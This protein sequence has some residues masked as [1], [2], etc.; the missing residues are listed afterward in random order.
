MPVSELELDGAKTGEVFQLD[1][2]D[3]AVR[4][5]ASGKIAIVVDDAEREN[6]GD[7]V[8]AAEKCSAEAMNFLVMHARGLVCAPLEREAA[9]RLE[10]DLMVEKNTDPNGTA[11]TVSVDAFEGVTTGISAAERATTARRLADPFAKPGDFRRP[12]HIFPLIARTGG[13][14]KRAGHTEAAVDLVRL[15]GFSGA[16]VICEILNEDGTMARLPDLLLLARRHGLR[17]VSVADLISYRLSREK[18]VKKMAEVKFP[19]K[20]GDFR[21]LAYKYA[22]DDNDE[23]VHLALVKGDVSSVGSV[24]VRVHSECLTGDTFGSF[25]CDC[26]EQ[27]HKSMAMIE[28]EGAGVLLYLR[29]EGRGIGLLAKLKAYELQ[30]RGMD[31]EE[32][33]LALG[34]PSDLRDYGVGAQILVDLGVNRIRLLTNNPRKIVSLEGYGLEIVERV[35]LEFPPNEYNEKYLHTKCGKM[36]HILHI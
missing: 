13:V 9:E 34:F 31:T 17:I 35:P 14:L 33:N 22:P 19:T 36:G 20:Y 12:G 28:Q 10:L 4:D 11:F 5:I 18:L 24:L 1:S 8:I 32:A 30:E 27:L 23:I 26:G 15:A 21:A 6:E 3:D 7:M 25:R 29:Q 2:I 16:G